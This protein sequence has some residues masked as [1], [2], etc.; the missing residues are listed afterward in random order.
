[1]AG[2]VGVREKLPEPLK[3]YFRAQMQGP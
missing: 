1:V 3:A 2:S